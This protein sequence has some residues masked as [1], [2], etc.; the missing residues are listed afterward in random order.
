MM[1]GAARQPQRQA[2]ADVVV[3]GEELQLLAE[4]AMVALLRL[5][6]HGEVGVQLG[7][8]LEGGAVDALELRVFLVAFVIGAGHVGE[9]ERADVAGAH[10]VRAGAEIDE[11]AV[12]IERDLL[13]LGNVLDDIEL[14]LARARPRAPSAASRPRA[15]QR[16]AS[17]R[18]HFHALE[19]VVRLDLLLHLGLDF[20]EILGRDAVRQFDVVV[21]AVLDRRA[22]GELRFRPEPEDG[23]GQDVGGGMADALQVGHRGR[24]GAG[25]GWRHLGSGNIFGSTEFV[26]IGHS[27][28]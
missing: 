28:G 7:L 15:A 2:G 13:A 1:R 14:E 27:F 4:L 24:S 10:D 6:E 11:I 9:L 23:G 12:A 20:L 25:G 19:G 5:L 17:S 22:G 21:E 26:G 3:E 18:E 16:K 8:V